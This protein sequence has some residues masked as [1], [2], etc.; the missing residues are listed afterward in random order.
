MIGVK[1][2]AK[3]VYDSKAAKVIDLRPSSVDD[4]GLVNVRFVMP[5]TS[6]IDGVDGV[7]TAF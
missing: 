7:L 4:D 3:H 1:S 2:H 5:A 6:K